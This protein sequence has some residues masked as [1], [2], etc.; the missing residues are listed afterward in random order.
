MIGGTDGTKYYTG[1]EN[2]VF[3]DDPDVDINAK[4]INSFSDIFDGGFTNT[5]VRLPSGEVLELGK[6]VTGS[7]VTYGRVRL[8][9]QNG[10]KY[11]VDN[12]NLLLVK[13]AE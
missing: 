13:E 9:D 4:T 3:I 2:C 6:T 11:Y 7:L 5:F 12:D 8:T 1:T 10:F